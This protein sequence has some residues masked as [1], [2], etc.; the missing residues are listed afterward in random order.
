MNVQQLDAIP[1]E[2]FEPMLQYI[3]KHP[4][5]NTKYRT[6]VG[7]GRSQTF[8]IVGRRCLSPDLSRTT[9]N[10]V[11]LFSLLL[12]FAKVYVPVPFSSIQV[13]QNYNCKSHLD[14]HNTGLSYIVAFGQYTGGRLMIQDTHYDIQYKPILFDGSKLLH[15]TF[16]FEGERISIVFHTIAPS[17]RFPLIQSLQ[18][19]EIVMH[20]GI[21]KI[22]HIPT[23]A[24]LHKGKTPDHYLKGI[25]RVTLNRDT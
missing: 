22:H 16:D 2:V 11:E 25:K 15:S 13:N 5:Q 1:P 4:I 24:M 6:K 14:L 8:G 12:D 9:C 18:Q 3:Q 20:E 17:K 23:G 19:Y 10:H 21:K 7:D